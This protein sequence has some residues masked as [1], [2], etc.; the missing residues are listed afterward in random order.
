MGSEQLL[1][2][3]E[4]FRDSRQQW[5]QMVAVNG[6]LEASLRRLIDSHQE[7]ERNTIA[8][9]QEILEVAHWLN[10]TVEESGA[11]VQSIEQLTSRA[12]A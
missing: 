8:S 9:H 12:L 11:M 2:S 10:Q 4:W 7:R 1:V 3:A 5:N 6:K